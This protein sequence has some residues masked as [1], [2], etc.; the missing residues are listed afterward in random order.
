MSS[1]TWSRKSMAI[2]LAVAVLSVYSMVVLATPGQTG[3]TGELSVSGQVSV[4]G[5]NAISGATVFSDSTVTTAKGSSAVVSLGKLS[6]VEVLPES[7]VK[8]SFNETSISGM[9]DSGRVR[10]SSGSGVSVNI[11]TKD[12][13]VVA[14]GSQAAVFTVNTEAG[15]TVVNTQSGRVELRSGGQVQQVAAG[16]EAMA[17]TPLPGA[18]SS[19]GSAQSDDGLS[20]GALAVLLLAAGGA[21]AA[22]I[23]AGTSEGNDIDVGGGTTIVS[24]TK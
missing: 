14:D 3:T 11:M 6:R 20:G 8:L 10:V 18:A 24:P 1:R 21:I 23:I 5:Q 2:G 13:V 15:N 19:K 12:G 22:A 16:S 7:S 9:L 17:G 4:N